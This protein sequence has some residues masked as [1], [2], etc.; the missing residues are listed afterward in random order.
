[1]IAPPPRYESHGWVVS[2]PGAV[3]T[4][5]LRTYFAYDV[6][7]AIPYAVIAYCIGLSG[8]S[9]LEYFFHLMKLVRIIK[10]ARLSARAVSTSLLYSTDTSY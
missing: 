1:M 6:A 7:C 4:R 9:N 2:H 5:Y 8:S 3:A 10:L